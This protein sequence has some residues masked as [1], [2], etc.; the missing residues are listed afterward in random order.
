MGMQR[1]ISAAHK[2][3]FKL[4][5]LHQKG[6]F[7]RILRI[8]WFL[9]GAMKEASLGKGKIYGKVL[10]CEHAQGNHKKVELENKL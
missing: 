5:S 2:K 3:W 4:V 7:S 6:H 8:A 1:T 10:S 9:T